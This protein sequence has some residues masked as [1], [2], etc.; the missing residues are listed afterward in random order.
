MT[1]N[2]FL[3]IIKLLSILLILNNILPQNKLI[4]SM[5]IAKNAKTLFLL[6]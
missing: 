6:L 1:L 2:S 3:K 5:S 4:H